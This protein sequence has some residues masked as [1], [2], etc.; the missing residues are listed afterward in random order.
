MTDRV[1]TLIAKKLTGNA[2]AKELKELNELLNNDP[3]LAEK[4]QIIENFFYESA[5]EN[6]DEEQTSRL[7]DYGRR[8]STDSQCGLVKSKTD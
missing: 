5:R 1:W 8:S 6:K 4:S 3:V 7:T 2:S